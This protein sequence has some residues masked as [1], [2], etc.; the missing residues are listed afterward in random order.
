M[1]KSSSYSGNIDGSDIIKKEARG[2]NNEDLGEVQEV[3][4][5]Y[6]LV[7]KGIINKEK[8]YIPRDFAVGYNGTIIIFNISIEDAK[9]KFLRDSPP[10]LS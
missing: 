10:V 6:V 1:P 3:T 9:N 5:D 2:I 8:F 4:Q 7:E